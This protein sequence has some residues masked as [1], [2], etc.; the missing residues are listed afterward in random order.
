MSGNPSSPINPKLST[1]NHLYSMGQIGDVHVGTAGGGDGGEAQMIADEHV[2]QR[3]AVDGEAD[4]VERMD[5]EPEHD[6]DHHDRDMPAEPAIAPNIGSSQLT[7]SFQGEVYVF[8]SVS[9]E[10][11]QA[12]LLL[13][14]G[15]EI[16]NVVPSVPLTSPPY[17]KRSNFPHRV[18]S[19]MRFREKRKERN[20]DKKIRYT[21]R[22]EVALRMQRNKGQF[23]SSKSKPEDDST[24]SVA[25]WDATQ[26]WGAVDGRPQAASECH[27]C[28]LSAKSTPMMR[29]GPEGPR[30]LCNAC[31]LMWA[32]KG[33]LK[34]LSKNPSQPLQNNI[35][36]PKEGNGTAISVTE[37]QPLAVAS[38]GHDSL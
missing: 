19:L 32:N 20:F 15:R 13:L 2:I 9:P 23:T 5:E 4:G 27:H 14:G 16:M 24:Q 12:V 30:T 38:S 34:D 33:L 18:A 36:V 37:Q 3:Y 10:K 31:G 29:R 28:G 1:G 26:R 11:V 6:Q 25:T 7:L 8:D 22:K 35:S 17:N 21:V